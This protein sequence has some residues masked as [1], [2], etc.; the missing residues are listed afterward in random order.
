MLCQVEGRSTSQNDFEGPPAHLR[1]SRWIW[2]EVLDPH[3]SLY[4][5]TNPW[6]LIQSHLDLVVQDTV[7]NDSG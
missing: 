6:L 3:N 4:R 1:L 5:L 7:T 2:S